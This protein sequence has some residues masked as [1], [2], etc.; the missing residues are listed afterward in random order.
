M[1]IFI[2]SN[3]TLDKSIPIVLNSSST[4]DKDDKRA[5]PEAETSHQTIEVHYMMHNIGSNVD[6]KTNSKEHDTFEKLPSKM[7]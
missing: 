1:S 2:C 3:G 5:K 7:R 4:N 6:S